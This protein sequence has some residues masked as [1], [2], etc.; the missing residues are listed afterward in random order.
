MIYFLWLFAFKGSLG[1]FSILA[2]SALNDA[3][4][5][6]CWLHLA[7]NY[8]VKFSMF[9]WYP[10][11]FPYNP[12]SSCRG[13]NGATHTEPKE[14]G[15]KFWWVPSHLKS[16]VPIYLPLKCLQLQRGGDL[17]RVDVVW[18]PVHPGHTCWKTWRSSG[19]E[20]EVRVLGG[21]PHH[22]PQHLPGFQ[23]VK[24]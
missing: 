18:R 8:S 15:E 11:P 22:L 13:S 16:V 17:D 24:K 10:L 6:H 3:K 14:F 19:F 7:W 1:I 2:A 12:C 4:S 20:E 9:L 23:P 21:R 5:H